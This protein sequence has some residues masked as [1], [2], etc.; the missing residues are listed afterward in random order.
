MRL[1]HSS[2][3]SMSIS[4]VQMPSTSRIAPPTIASME[5]L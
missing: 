1:V 2:S 3:F 4:N 5:A